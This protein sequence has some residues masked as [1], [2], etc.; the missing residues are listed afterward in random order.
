MINLDQMGSRPH[1]SSGEESDPVREL[2][3]ERAGCRQRGELRNLCCPQ[4]LAGPE[5][6]GAAAARR[7]SQLR[8]PLVKSKHG[9]GKPNSTTL[10]KAYDNRCAIT[11]CD[12]ESVLQAAHVQAAWSEQG[13]LRDERSAAS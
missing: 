11:N 7:T 9:S 6:V 4:N 3:T 1:R 13:P 2:S 12:V 5:S 10:M 8:L